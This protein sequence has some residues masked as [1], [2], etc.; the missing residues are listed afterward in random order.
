[1]ERVD[2]KNKCSICYIAAY[3]LVSGFVGCVKT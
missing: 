2:V 3:V 1:M